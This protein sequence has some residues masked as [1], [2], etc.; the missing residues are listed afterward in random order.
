MRSLTESREHQDE[1]I[2]DY[3]E[4][5][6]IDVNGVYKDVSEKREFLQNVMGY[7]GLRAAGKDQKDQFPP[8]IRCTPEKIS[9]VVKGI[10]SGAKKRLQKKK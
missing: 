9:V 6:R 3:I 4:R 1:R 10:Y 5:R 2:V 8:L 7:N